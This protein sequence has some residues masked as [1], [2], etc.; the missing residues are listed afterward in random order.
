MSTASC[1]STCS[2]HYVQYTSHY[3]SQ[4]LTD[5]SQ[6]SGKTV[7]PHYSYD[8]GNA[9]DGSSCMPAKSL[10]AGA[11]ASGGG[12]KAVKSGGVS[13]DE[14][15]RE[16]VQ[17]L[18]DEFP[19]S[20]EKQARRRPG[21]RSSAYLWVLRKS[22]WRRSSTCISHAV[23]TRWKRALLAPPRSLD[24]DDAD[25]GEHHAQ[26]QTPARGG[27][28]A[29][30]CGHAAPLLPSSN[31]NTFGSAASGGNANTTGGA[32]ASRAQRSVAS[33]SA[34]TCCVQVHGEDGERS[35]DMQLFQ[36]Q[37]CRCCVSSATASYE[38]R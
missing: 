10:L 38:A 8:G 22:T 6:V 19:H 33:G 26:R 29:S 14:P 24:D 13:Q 1:E 23:S 25:D 18:L 28:A 21:A 27:T 30:A 4:P 36:L 12:A 5:L 20:N 3:D 16:L 31:T 35:D 7:M 17:A 11:K 34:V 9:D 2:E 37:A 15:P 32:R